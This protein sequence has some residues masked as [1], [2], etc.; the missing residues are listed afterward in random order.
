M[1]DDTGDIRSAKSKLS[2]SDIGK[3]VSFRSMKKPELVVID[4]YA[5]LWVIN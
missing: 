3:K 2:L 1:F 5:I 4:G